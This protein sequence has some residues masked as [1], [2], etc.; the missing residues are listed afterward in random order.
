MRFI[1]ATVTLLIGLSFSA[2]SQ[3]LSVPDDMDKKAVKYYEKGKEELNQSKPADAIES[4]TKALDRQPDFVSAQIM[5]GSIY[6]NLKDYDSAEK[7]FLAV[8][9]SGD[10]FPS[11]VYYSLAFVQWNLDKFEAASQNFQKFLD[12]DSTN[13]LLRLK[14]EKLQKT[15]AF[16]A[17]AVAN[18]LPFNPTSVGENIN[19]QANEYL[20]SLTADGKTMFFTRR[21][22]SYEFLYFSEKRDGQWSEPQSMEIINQYMESGAHAISADGKLIVFTSCERDDGYGSCDLYYTLQ[23]NGQWIPPRNLGPKVNSAAWDSQPSLADNGRTLYFASNRQGTLGK[24]DIWVTHRTQ[25]GSWSRPKN[26]G[27]TINT[28]G[29]EK[30]PYI[31]FDGSTLYFMSNEHIGLGDFDLFMSNKNE[32]Q[33]S[34][35]VNV[36]YPLNSKFHDGTLSINIQGD[37]G[38]ITSD[39]HHQKDLRKGDMS[40]SETDIFVFDVPLTIQPHPSTFVVFRVTEAKSNEP[41]IAN[42]NVMD[43]NQKTIFKDL[44]DEDG[45]ML[46]VLPADNTYSIQ[47]QHDDFAF[48]SER[49]V[50]DSFYTLDQPLVM[51]IKLNHPESLESE[52]VV[53]KNILFKSGSD[54]L[55]AASDNEIDYLYRLLRDN[56]KISIEIRGHTDNVGAPEDNLELSKA[57]ADRVKDAL[58]E[59]GISGRRI[60]TAGF[61]ETQ[62]L[63]DNDTETGRRLNRRT[64][65][66]ILTK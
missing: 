8:V 10:T 31:H 18:P 44:T 47:V 38:Y 39:R 7:D 15:T 5:R 63:A 46:V 51:N 66:V 3:R 48:F 36:G 16:S 32:D 11:K 35:P 6:Y 40:R 17:E 65:F 54:Q 19:T 50:I 57:R 43:V 13:E 9:N 21:V 37:R 20:P 24:K 53:L 60:T 34:T 23:R 26:L 22:G 1:L 25:D 61:G 30:A 4:F 28:P 59:K 45:E 52:P 55:E 33:W 62:P 49:L 58:I 12:S 41:L 56:A 2:C 29:D 42:I 27:P 14:A 64:E